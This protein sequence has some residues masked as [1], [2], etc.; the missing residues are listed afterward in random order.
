MSASVI[1]ALLATAGYGVADYLSGVFSRRLRI[2]DVLTVGY[3]AGLLVFVPAWPLLASTGFSP[4]DLA[5]GALAGCAGAVGVLLL[6][7][8][9]RVGQF[10]VVSPVSAVGTAAIPVAAGLLLG[11]QPGPV[12][13]AGLAVGVVAIALVSGARIAPRVWRR[14]GG[15]TSAGFWSGL[16]SGVAYAGMFLALS[17]SDYSSGPWP[18][19]ALQ[20]GLLAVIGG[21][22]GARRQRPDVR[23]S[24]WPGVAAVGITSV[25]GNLAFVYAARL[26]LVSIAAVIASM[27]PAVTVLLARVVTGERFSRRQ[28]LGLAH[29]VAALVLIGAGPEIAG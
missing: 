18:V 17:R 4:A 26:G 11:E 15:G 20:F 3:T 22:V 28:L 8:G 2:L 12:T 13:F 29:A 24:D 19:L 1:L 21:V 7:H 5:W 6:L 14:V 9:F 10:A 27:S 16:G 23:A 25:V